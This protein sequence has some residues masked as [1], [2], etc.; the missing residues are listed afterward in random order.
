MKET[1]LFYSPEVSKTHQLPDDEAVHAVRVL[2]LGEGDE[3]W[4]T[5]GLGQWYDCRVTMATQK[6]CAVQIEGTRQ[7][8]KPWQS[9]IHL[10]VAPTKN[11]DRIE[12]FAEKATEIGVDAIHFVECAN[13]E[14]RVIKTERVNKIVVSAMKQSHKALLP[15][16]TPLQRFKDF[17]SQPFEGQKFIA[18]CYD[19]SDVGGGDKPF[20]MDCVK[21]DVPTLVLVGPEGDFS[22]DEV[23]VAEAAGFVSI[24]LGESRLR[25]ETAALAAVYQMYL[26]KK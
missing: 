10:A 18:H 1:H 26:K 21:A 2:R 14:R 23:R 13:S 17:V 9:D 4:I 12:W 6:R 5:D 25:T 16:V 8:Q 22:I 19:Q 20:L 15:K 11:M 24:S 3:V 7:W